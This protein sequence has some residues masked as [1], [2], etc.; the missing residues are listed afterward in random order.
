MSSYLI[1]IPRAMVTVGSQEADFIASG[2]NVQDAIH[3]A[4]DR[5]LAT[6]GKG[7]I[8][9]KSGSYTSSQPINLGRGFVSLRGAGRNQTVITLANGSNCDMITTPDDGIQGQ[10]LDISDLKLDGNAANQSSGHVFNIRAMNEST[11]SNCLIVNPKQDGIH[12]G[13]NTV[14]MF[15][16]NPQ[17]SRC[18]FTADPVNTT[19][20]G[21]SLQSGS[22]DCQ[23]EH[24]DIGYFKQG[25]GIV[26]SGH[27]GGSV[28]H[29]NSWQCKYGFQLYNS[30][31]TRM[32]NLLSD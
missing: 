26:L 32:V 19:G 24:I 27:N 28:S 30:D 29:I 13:Q 3:A 5:I 25:S 23:L 18:R 22:S 1:T 14:G 10:W 15:C 20:D 31:R 9:I 16:T 7:C 8:L 6:T 21:I 12:Y 11:I 4:R 2:S 17:I